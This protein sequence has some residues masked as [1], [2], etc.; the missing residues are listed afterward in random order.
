MEFVRIYD[1]PAG[2][3]EEDE[4]KAPEYMIVAEAIVKGLISAESKTR[5]EESDE[6]FH[7]VGEAF[8]DLQTKLGEQ[9][10]ELARGGQLTEEVS[11]QPI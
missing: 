10:I 6:A 5:W 8:N 9:V 3:G 7:L 2:T 11:Y 1:S 4:D